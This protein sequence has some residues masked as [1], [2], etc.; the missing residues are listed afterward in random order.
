MGEQAKYLADLNKKLDK[1]EKLK[2]KKNY[3]SRDEILN[4]V[5]VK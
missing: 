2:S 3:S 4:S 5:Q 1:E